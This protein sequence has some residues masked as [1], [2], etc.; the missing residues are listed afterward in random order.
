VTS[1]GIAA[2]TA[3]GLL[4]G[5]WAM[6]HAAL[7]GFGV[8]FPLQLIAATFDGPAA[9]VGGLGAAAAGLCLHLLVSV[10][11]GVL[12]AAIVDRDATFGVA[13]VGGTALALTALMVLTFAVVPLVN[14]TMQPR[15]GATPGSWFVQHLIFG[16]GLALAPALRRRLALPDAGF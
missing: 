12:F 8:L 9:L 15:I 10:A 1:A 13:L 4:M 16:V 6:A 14:P 5:L 3:G 2:G 7:E 11:V